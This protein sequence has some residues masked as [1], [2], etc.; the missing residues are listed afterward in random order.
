MS[1]RD[2]DRIVHGWTADGGE[3]ARYDRAGKWYIEYPSNT[4]RKRR[5]VT[6]DEAAK[7][8]I[9]GKVVLGRYGGTR[10]DALVR[11]LQAGR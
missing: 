8:A 11:A 3:I 1:P 10:F 4:D 7:A 6:L 5:Q 2:F 9:A